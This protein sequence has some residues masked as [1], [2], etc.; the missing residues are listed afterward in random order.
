[1]KYIL[2]SNWKASHFYVLPKIPK[3]KNIIEEINES[4]NICLNMQP[5]DD[6]KGRP[7]VGGP[8]SPNQSVSGLLEKILTPIFS[9]LKTYINDDWDFIRK[10]PSHVDYPCV[11]ANCDVV[12]LYTSI[13]HDLGLETL[14]YW[15]NKQRNLIQERFTKTYILEAAS[16]VLSNNNF[17]FDSH[18][19]LQLVGTAMGT[20]FALPY[21]CLSVGYLEETISF[22]Q[23]YLPL[24][25]TLTEC[26]LIREIFKRFMDDGFVLWPKNVNIDV[27]RELLNELHPSLKFTVKKG[28]HSCEQNF[29]TF[30]QVLNFLNVSINLHQNGRLETDIFYKETNSHDY[31]NYFSHHPEHTKQNISYNLAKR[32]TVFVS[33]EEKMNERLSELRT[34]LLS[35]S[36]PLTL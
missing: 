13:S 15:I 31:L 19:F 17:Q 25:F 2:N 6:L 3:S 28:K 24:R 21:A 5:P 4:N 18:T 26:K 35:R 22:T 7:I 10:L 8:N 36:Y 34:W 12:S 20:K 1:M 14:S 29:D 16:F 9:C 32:I 33:D 23:F 11:L 27:F 30:V